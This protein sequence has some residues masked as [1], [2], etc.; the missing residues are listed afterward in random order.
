MPV[1]MFLVLEGQIVMT[2]DQVMTDYYN[3]QKGSPLSDSPVYNNSDEAN[4]AAIADILPK[5]V[6]MA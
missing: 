2:R 5:T 6:L 3:A 1:E 4:S